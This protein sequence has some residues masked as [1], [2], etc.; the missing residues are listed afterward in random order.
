MKQLTQMEQTE[1]NIYFWSVDCNY[2]I[3]ENINFLLVAPD[4]ADSVFPQVFY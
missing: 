3:R 4:I 1:Y 2:E